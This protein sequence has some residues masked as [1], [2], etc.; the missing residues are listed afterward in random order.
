MSQ[1]FF[2]NGKQFHFSKTLNRLLFV[3]KQILH[4]FFPHALIFATATT[5]PHITH[6][7]VVGLSL[8][9]AAELCFLRVHPTTGC[10]SLCSIL[11]NYPLLPTHTHS[12]IHSLTALRLSKLYSWKVPFIS[13]EK[14]TSSGWHIFSSFF[15]SSGYNGF[16]SS[17][18]FTFTL[19]IELFLRKR[20]QEEKKKTRILSVFRISN[21]GTRSKFLR[22][23]GNSF[24]PENWVN[25]RQRRLVCRNIHS[26]SAMAWD[27]RPFRNGNYMDQIRL[28]LPGIARMGW[29]GP[30]FVNW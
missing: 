5:I 28:S 9:W 6:F 3:L 7:N 18:S 25:F 1:F 10:L 12:Y 4:G 23:L 29:A 16:S 21:R 27:E 26:S 24:C 19:W 11:E 22:I 30:G 20:E 14:V 15:F 2:W 8:A 13:G 17:G